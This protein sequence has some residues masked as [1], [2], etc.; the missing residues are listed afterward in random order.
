M[1][2]QS[3]KVSKSAIVVL[4]VSS[5]SHSSNSGNNSSRMRFTYLGPVGEDVVLD[6]VHQRVSQ[7]L[8]GVGDVPELRHRHQ[9]LQ[10]DV[11]VHTRLAALLHLLDVEQV[12]RRRGELVSVRGVAT[13]VLEELAVAAE[14]DEGGLVEMR[15]VRRRFAARAVALEDGL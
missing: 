8:G 2:G 9:R 3:K 5:G 12:E 10:Q 14:S 1:V 11:V 7:A 13:Q 15:D 6:H 4:V